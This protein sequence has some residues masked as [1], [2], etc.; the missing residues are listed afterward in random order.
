MRT[1][2]TRIVLFNLGV[3]CPLSIVV[4]GVEHFFHLL[5][6]FSLQGRINPIYHIIVRLLLLLLH[7]REFLEVLFR[8]FLVALG[9]S[10]ESRWK[11][12]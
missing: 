6:L 10:G 8:F 5:E 9:H 7:F 2:C 1:A 12:L 3:S 4:Q 11:G